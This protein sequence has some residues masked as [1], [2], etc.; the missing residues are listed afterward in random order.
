MKKDYISPQ[1]EIKELLLGDVLN[2]S[3]NTFDLDGYDDND[4]DLP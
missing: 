1:F 3:N 4:F 2:L